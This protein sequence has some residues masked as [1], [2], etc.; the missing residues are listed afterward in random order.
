MGIAVH[1][2]EDQLV[3]SLYQQP[4]AAIDTHCVSNQWLQGPNS[5]NGETNGAGRNKLQTRKFQDQLVMVPNLGTSLSRVECLN[6][7]I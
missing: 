2:A 6:T 7:S 5:V 1:R 3:E 4:V